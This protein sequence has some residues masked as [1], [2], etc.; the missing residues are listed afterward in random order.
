MPPKKTMSE[1]RK[2][3]LDYGSDARNKWLADPHH[4]EDTEVSPVLKDM[5]SEEFDPFFLDFTTYIRTD[6]QM[7]DVIMT[8]DGLRNCGKFWADIVSYVFNLQ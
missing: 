6:N 2:I 8:E 1:V 3:V 7:S 5:P 4:D